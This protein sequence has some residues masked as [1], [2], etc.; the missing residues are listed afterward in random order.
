MISINRCCSSRRNSRTPNS[1][2][3]NPNANPRF[4]SLHL[5][6]HGLHK[7][8]RRRSTSCWGLAIW[9]V[10]F[11]TPLGIN[12]G[13]WI[14][15]VVDMNSINI[16]SIDHIQNYRERSLLGKSIRGIHP[17]VVFEIANHRGVSFDNMISCGGDLTVRQ[18]TKW[19]KPSMNL[20]SS[21]MCLL[22][23]ICQWIITRRDPLSPTDP[24][25]PRLEPRLING[26][27]IRPYLKNNRVHFHRC[28]S[29]QHR[30]HFSLLGTRTHSFSRRP[31][32]IVNTSNPSR[33][34]FS[35]HHWCDFVD[36]RVLLGLRKP[37]KQ[38]AGN[39]NSKR[40][41]KSLSGDRISQDK[42]RV[43]INSISLPLDLPRSVRTHYL[44]D[45]PALVD[46]L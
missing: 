29:V 39:Y 28:H 34:K 8:V 22:D 25:A 30:F 4:L 26:I 36:Y 19:I 15:I 5:G 44:L 12:V 11:C 23:T 24:V 9:K 38:K 45:E 16:V 7:S 17:F 35:R 3:A 18:R 42:S 14:K 13:I 1:K 21:G 31:I 41:P 32:N 6:I 46:I 40:H 43:D 2:W 10:R 33:P 37:R 20:Y 27:S